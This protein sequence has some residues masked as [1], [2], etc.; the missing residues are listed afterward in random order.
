MGLLSWLFPSPQQ[1]LE[2]ARKEL[3]KGRFADARLMALEVELPEAAGIVDLAEQEL[4]RLN[5]AHALS[6][7]EA[8]DA[9]K[10]DAHFEL[11]ERFAR[12]TVM[13]ELRQATREAQRVLIAKAAAAKAEADTHNARW[14]EVD[15]R[16]FDAHGS[17]DLPMPEGVS[18]EDAEALHAR[19]AIAYENYPE[20]LRQGMLRL[21][22]DFAQAIL[23]IDDG[24]A[25]EAAAALARLPDT[26]PLVLHERARAA[27]TLGDA[28]SAA[29]LWTA[30]AA[31]AGG[32]HTIGTQHTGVLAAHCLA[33]TGDLDGATAILTELRKTDVRNGG[34]L[35]ASLLEA[36]GDLDGAEALLKELLQKTG[37]QPPVYTAI[38]RIRAA[39]GRRAEAMQ[40]LETGMRSCGCGTGKCGT[41][42]PDLAMY[43]ML[44]TLYLEDGVERERGLD[45]AA[46]A[47]DLVQQPQWDDLYLSTLAARANGD[48]DWPQ[49]ATALRQ[50]TPE[51]DPRRATLDRYLPIVA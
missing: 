49:R 18:P 7:A 19:I 21:G 38:A 35:L 1:K 15:D 44:A 43:R 6:W 27:L 29:A 8:G 26:E 39:T 4:C 24:K 14:N 3:E 30:F 22:A 23:D 5:I 41:F 46:Q 48:G 42:P 25:A 47:R 33:R 9:E 13:A 10:V 12:P 32:H 37:P 51:G 2:A 20:A 40:A 11:A 31:V 17:E 50:H 34:G 28:R 36:K 16:F 45:L